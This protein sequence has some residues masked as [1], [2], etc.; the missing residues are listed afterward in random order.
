MEI[1]LNRIKIKVRNYHN[2]LTMKKDR[3]SMSMIFWKNFYLVVG[4]VV[5][6]G[7][8]KNKEKHNPDMLKY[9]FYA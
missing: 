6:I 9:I 4:G 2:I 1:K 5:R 8:A 3:K 7:I